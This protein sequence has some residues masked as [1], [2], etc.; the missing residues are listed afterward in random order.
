MHG[1][2]RPPRLDAGPF[3]PDAAQAPAPSKLS[4]KSYSTQLTELYAACNKVT[5][6][7]SLER[8]GQLQVLELGG[9]RIRVLQGAY[10]ARPGRLLCGFQAWLM[11]QAGRQPRR[12]SLATLLA[13]SL[14]AS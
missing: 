6:I 14:H 4:R 13:G 10:L 7:E 5:T 2:R 3:P 9:N 8:L 12:P 1:A 11:A